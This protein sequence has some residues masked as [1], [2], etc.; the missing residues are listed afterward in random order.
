MPIVLDAS[1][2]GAWCLPDE[3]EPMTTRIL[4][5][6]DHETALVPALFWFEIRNVLVINERRGRLTPEESAAFLLDLGR[7]S[8]DVDREP[9]GE[10]VLT[11]ARR[12]RL[13]VYDA[14]YL[15]LARRSTAPLAT[16]DRRLGAAAEAEGIA[17]VG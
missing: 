1:I 9:S 17:L 4:R 8:L 2:A 12:H 15:E 11:L 10:A 16:L 14:A 6:L 5:R 13:T 7:L 3:N